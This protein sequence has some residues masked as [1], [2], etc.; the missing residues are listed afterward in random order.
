MA[1]PTTGL[2]HIY[3]PSRKAERDANGRPIVD[4]DFPPLPEERLHELRE[5]NRRLH[6]SPSQAKA[7]ARKEAAPRNEFE[8]LEHE[9]SE[10]RRS[11]RARAVRQGLGT[12]RRAASASTSL[13]QGK[14]PSSQGPG[15]TLAGVLLGLV[16]T[17]FFVNLLEG[18]PAQAI[19]WLG[20]KFINK[21]YNPGGSQATTVAPKEA[22]GPPLTQPTVGNPQ[23][24]T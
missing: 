3:H 2:E 20:A 15:G 1:A 12:A 8:R 22:P 7:R 14:R 13:L 21:P 4:D 16:A 17:A 24:A 11:D 9:Q 6:E 10:A 19:G 5:H 23:G 18:G